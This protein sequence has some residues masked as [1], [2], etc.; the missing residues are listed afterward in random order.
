[1]IN[2]VF[3]SE[4]AEWDARALESE[5]TEA[6]LWHWSIIISILW[7]FAVCVADSALSVSH[8]TKL[9]NSQSRNLL[10]VWTRGLGL[11][12]LFL[13][14]L[15]VEHLDLVSS[16]QVTWD[17]VNLTDRLLSSVSVLRTINGFNFDCN[18]L[19]LQSVTTWR[20]RIFSLSPTFIQSFTRFCCEK[21]KRN[22]SL[23]ELL[24]SG[25]NGQKW[26][27]PRWNKWWINLFRV[28]LWYQKRNESMLT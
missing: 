3:W 25:G 13:I 1:M 7:W 19:L 8:F 9:Q 23:A 5:N 21:K 4:R 27:F 15:Q 22:P 6:G 16:R 10:N 2:V 17:P 14:K 26:V 20:T 24:C 12:K 28:F 18:E 11:R